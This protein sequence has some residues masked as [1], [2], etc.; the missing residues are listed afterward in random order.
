MRDSFHQQLEHISEELTA[1][2][3]LVELAVTR[4]TDALLTGN[5]TLAEQVISGDA[6][7]D[8]LQKL[9][10]DEA[11]E[12]LALQ[13]PVASDLRALVATLRM[14][15]ELERMGDLAE[16]VA[17]IARLRYP[18]I[19][20]P[21]ELHD[22]FRRMGRL[23]AT[24]VRMSGL[25]VIERD[26][27][28]ARELMS[29]DDE[30]DQLR[31]SLFRATVD[32]SWQHGVEGAVDVALLGRYYERIADHCVSLARRVIYLV[33]GDYPPVEVPAIPTH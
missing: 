5:L 10:E 1:M 32:S 13:Q 20:V 16:H 11:F 6:S 30:M 28:A 17:K 21:R 24:M 26:V 19:A 18:D 4:S 2:A 9:V 29:L 14:V 3:R 8:A 23:A 27:A 22:T 25:N 7:V 15:A 12:Q 33:T 31:M